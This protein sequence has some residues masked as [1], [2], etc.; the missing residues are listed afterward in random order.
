M[1]AVST[2]EV[3][4]K[5][6]S[7]SNNLE[8]TTEQF[9]ECCEEAGYLE[10]PLRSTHFIAENSLKWGGQGEEHKDPFDR[11]LLAQAKSE[12]FY[13]MT[14]DSKIVLFDEECIVKV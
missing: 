8:F 14:H 12:A 7:K 10:L 6:K 1:S 13:L 5:R 9:I 4:N 11:L 2:L 3:N